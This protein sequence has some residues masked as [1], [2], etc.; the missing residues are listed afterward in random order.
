MKKKVLVTGARGQLGK[1]IIDLMSD[2]FELILTDYDDMDITNMDQVTSRFAKELPDFVIHAAAYTQVDKAE[3]NQ[4][5]CHKV[6]V[7]GTKNIAFACQ[8]IGSTLIYISTDYVFDGKKKTPYLENDSPNP[9]SVYGETKYLGEKEI[10]KICTNYYILRSSWIFGELPKGHPGTNFVET[11]IRLSKENNELSIINDQIGSPTYT[12][13]LVQTIESLIQ[14]APVFG[15]YHFSGDGSCS[16]YDFA[17]EVLKQ[18]NINI[19]IRPILSDEYPQKAKRP[20]YSYLN[21]SKIESALHVSIRPW[22]EMLKEY[23]RVR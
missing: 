23:L 16:W 6:N 21:K 3:D 1:K 14:K 4:E 9:M 18:S 12:K 10:E 20:S 11:M 7:M 17:V 22:Q 2:N 13:D 8:E 5:I 15:I 19:R